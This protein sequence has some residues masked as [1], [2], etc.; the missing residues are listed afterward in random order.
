[1]SGRAGDSARPPVPTRGPASQDAGPSSVPGT[2]GATPSAAAAPADPPPRPAGL[3][4]PAAREGDAAA[5]Q[6]V[7]AT[8]AARLDALLPPGARALGVAVSGGGD[9]VALL[10]ALAGAATARGLRLE[11]ATVD[12]GLRP[13]AAVEAAWTAALCARLG[14]PHATLRWTGR[15]AAGNLAEAA[16]EG[17]AALLA[18]WAA[19]RGLDAVA[20]AHTRDDQAETL[21][22][23]LARGSGLDG[24]SSMRPVSRRAG[25]LWLRPAL[26]T[27]RDDLRALLRAAGQAWVEDPSNADPARDR[28]RARLALEALS[29]L[30]I[31]P[32]G[33]AATAARLAGDGDA[34][35]EMAGERLAQA[36]TIGAAGEL[37]LPREALRAAPPALRRRMLA[38][39]LQA[40]AG[41]SHAPRAR[42]T[43]ALEAAIL[44]PEPLPART[45]GGCVVLGLGAGIVLHRE[46]AALPPP[47]APDATWDGRW[48]LEGPA[49]APDLR[50]GALGEAGLAALSALARA[51]AWTAPAPWAAAPRA[52]RRAAPALWRGARGEVLAAVPQAG[53]TL[54]LDHG[55]AQLQGAI[56]RDLISARIL[57]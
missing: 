57:R 1:M 28:T 5:S 40:L 2:P 45:L 7:R 8:L 47:V 29:G 32:A 26:E 11:A 50:L 30:G 41:A 20:L 27:S 21:L 49:P 6:S 52:A 10:L 13:Q 31:G 19:E 48:R 39:L 17:R 18:A 43:A 23:R 25:A 24:L 51:G 15:P 37:R 44:A 56:L 22:M 12:H 36:L 16:R 42:A 14:V 4:S 38:G 34:L 46:P 3:V 54:D 35:R 55:G 9:S 33:L 53:W